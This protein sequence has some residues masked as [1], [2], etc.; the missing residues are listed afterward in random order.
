M[1]EVYSIG[2]YN[3]TKELLK[4]MCL[5]LSCISSRAST[6]TKVNPI[7]PGMASFVIGLSCSDEGR[8]LIHSLN[9]PAPGL[10]SAHIVFFNSWC[11]S[12]PIDWNFAQYYILVYLFLVICTYLYSTNDNVS[13]GQISPA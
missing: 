10:F 2:H 13:I 9:S 7:I 1:Y 3:R 11:Y 8:L 12:L 6:Y 5:F 4:R